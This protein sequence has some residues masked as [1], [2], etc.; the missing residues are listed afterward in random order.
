MY[1][2]TAN[3]ALPWPASVRVI[4][5]PHSI[6]PSESISKRIAEQCRRKCSAYSDIN[7]VDLNW[8][9]PINGL[10][11]LPAGAASLLI[12]LAYRVLSLK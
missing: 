2:K 8:E 4:K 1:D 10:R 6:Q 11:V 9:R 7:F 3:V 5:S 12:H